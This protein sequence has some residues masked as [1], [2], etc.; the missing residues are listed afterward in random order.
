MFSTGTKRGATASTAACGPC[1]SRQRTN[2]RRKE[3]TTTGTAATASGRRAARSCRLGRDGYHL[4]SAEDGV[5][6]D[7]NGDGIPERVAWTRPDSDDA[8]LALDRNNNGRIDDGSELFGNHTPVYGDRAD[9]TTLN[10]FEA[11][12]FAEGPTWGASYAEGRI[13]ARDAIF[14]RLALVARSKP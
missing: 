2:A 11:L 10:G 4:T 14:S 8:F 1:S 3:Q 6:F 7:L 5:L 12:K 9:I 13:D